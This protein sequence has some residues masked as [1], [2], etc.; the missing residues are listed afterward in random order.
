MSTCANSLPMQFAFMHSVSIVSAICI[1]TPTF[2][3]FTEMKYSYIPI[4][5]PRP[6]LHRSIPISTPPF[7]NH[8]A[9]FHP[10]LATFS[11]SSL[12]KTS[13][14]QRPS[15]SQCQLFYSHTTNYK[16][17]NRQ[18]VSQAAKSNLLAFWQLYRQLDQERPCLISNHPRQIRQGNPSLS[19]RQAC[20]HHL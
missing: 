19:S 15:S 5:T 18:K 16:S 11:H 3:T 8:E 1:S 20:I 2:N 7:R 6:P 12:Y 9:S 13:L 4:S 17:R 10:L 14:Y